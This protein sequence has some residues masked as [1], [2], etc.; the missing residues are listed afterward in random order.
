MSSSIFC[1][2]AKILFMRILKF[3]LFAICFSI[4]ASSYSQNSVD[5]TNIKKKEFIFPAVNDF[6]NDNENIFKNHEKLILNTTLENFERS[7]NNKII[8]VTVASILPYD[9]IFKY[10]LDMANFLVSEK[11]LGTKILIVLSKN[12]RQ[13][14]IQN[15]DSIANLLTDEETKNI[16]ETFI[17]PEFKKG[18]YF[19]GLK[20]GISE[21]KKELN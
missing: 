2:L 8:I 5:S 12:L 15:S 19:K 16:L 3:I 9:D 4:S 6:V 21:I 11:Q 13:I 20:K 14:Q 7:S 17:I 18:D 10:S 1:R